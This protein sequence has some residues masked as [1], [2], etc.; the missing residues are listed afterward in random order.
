MYALHGVLSI[1][2]EE[3]GMVPLSDATT[4]A[5]FLE[6]DDN[7]TMHNSQIDMQISTRRVEWQGINYSTKLDFQFE[8]K[9][10]H[11]GS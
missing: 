7:P 4:T 5:C 2:S 8:R 11:A 3:I 9:H 6:A 1:V 10:L